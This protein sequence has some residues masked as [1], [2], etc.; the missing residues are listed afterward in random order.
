MKTG[1]CCKFPK[2]GTWS[3]LTPSGTNLIST[4]DHDKALIA[5][6][7]F[8]SRIIEGIAEGGVRMFFKDGA[9]DY[10]NH[11]LVA[12]ERIHANM[13]SKGFGFVAKVLFNGSRHRVFCKR[14]DG[15]DIPFTSTAITPIEVFE[16]TPENLGMI[17]QWVNE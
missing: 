3:Y 1:Y 2:A 4:F 5:D 16:N 8:D 12:F 9:L 15:S 13:T 7:P 17:H 14:E 11:D 10:V 6:D